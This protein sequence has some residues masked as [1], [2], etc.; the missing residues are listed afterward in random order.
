MR[1]TRFS[2]SDETPKNRDFQLTGHFCVPSCQKHGFFSFILTDWCPIYLCLTNMFLFFSPTF[3]V[4]QK[5]WSWGVGGFSVGQ[6]FAQSYIA[7][8]DFK[9]QIT[10]GVHLIFFPFYCLYRRV[11]NTYN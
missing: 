1:G 9:K 3:W 4:R 10:N 11:F 6:H 2:T 7:R 8:R 5:E